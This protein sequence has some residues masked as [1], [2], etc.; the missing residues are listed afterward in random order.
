MKLLFE[1]LP[2]LVLPESYR[3][4]TGVSIIQRHLLVMGSLQARQT[5]G[6]KLMGG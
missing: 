2:S 4:D 3:K 5:S 6:L 1:T